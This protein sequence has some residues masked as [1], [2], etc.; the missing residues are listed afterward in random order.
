[1]LLSIKIK[2][3]RDEKYDT[4]LFLKNKTSFAMIKT[5]GIVLTFGHIKSSQFLFY[6]L[7]K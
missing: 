2:D 1:M 3:I 4:L 6:F 5:M 7:K